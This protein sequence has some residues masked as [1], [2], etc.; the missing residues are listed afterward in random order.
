[1]PPSARTIEPVVKL[2]ASDTKNSAA[3]TIS[4]G[5]PARLQREVPERVG[6]V[7]WSRFQALLMSVK[8]GSGHQRVDPHGGPE[9]LGQPFGHGVE[10]GLGRGVGDDVGTR[11]QRPGG[12][13]V[14]DGATAG[15]HHPLADQ[16]RKPERA[17]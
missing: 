6:R 16:R 1:M 9:R 17:L 10:A 2:D 4:G 3:P 8:K 15:G 14:D 11:A 5:S 12:T 13:D 7:A